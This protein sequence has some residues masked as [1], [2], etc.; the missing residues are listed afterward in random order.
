MKDSPACPTGVHAGRS[1]LCGIT[2]ETMAT[3]FLVFTVMGTAIDQRAAPGVY[4]MCIGGSLT[5]SVL[6]IGNITGAALNP[7]RYFGP[8][9][10]GA[11]IL[12]HW[13]GSDWY[14]YFAPFV[15][16]LFAAL[17]YAFVFLED[18]K[19]EEVEGEVEVNVELAEC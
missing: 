9:I 12:G 2:L 18:P 16:G 5:M 7:F 15:G 19:E 17:M 8:Q 14:I 3:F 11:I 1:I 10:G 6:G 4:G 13:T